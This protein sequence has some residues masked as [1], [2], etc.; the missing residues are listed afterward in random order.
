MNAVVNEVQSAE[1]RK[2]MVKN[3]THCV[4][5][6]QVERERLAQKCAARNGLSSSDFRALLHI[7]ESELNEEPLAAGGLR[8]LMNMSAG[9][10]T[11]VVDRLVSAGHVRREADP[12]DRRKVVLRHTAK[13]E[14]TTGEFFSAIE[15]RNRTALSDVPA[16]DIATTER[17]IGTLIEYIH[18]NNGR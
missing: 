14:R 7:S 1:Q 3:L 5:R 4:R 18:Q 13:G 15:Q 10:A 12:T 2:T 17:V 11:Y 16:A 6:L 9:A 8:D